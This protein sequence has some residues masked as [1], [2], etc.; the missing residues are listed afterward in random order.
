MQLVRGETRTTS[1]GRCPLTGATG[2][3][4]PYRASLVP[5]VATESSTGVKGSATGPTP[6]VNFGSVTSSSTARGGG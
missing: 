3:T 5:P 1:L 6:T 2:R 4:R